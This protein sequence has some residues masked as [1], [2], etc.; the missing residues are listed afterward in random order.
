MTPSVGNL[1]N[2]S[3]VAKKIESW[4]HFLRLSM[5]IVGEILGR[6]NDHKCQLV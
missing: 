6:S 2:M 5:L 1:Q 3:L 4:R